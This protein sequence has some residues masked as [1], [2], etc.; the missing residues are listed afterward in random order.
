MGAFNDRISCVVRPSLNPKD[1]GAAVDVGE[2]G[3]EENSG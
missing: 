3:F 1:V 2:P